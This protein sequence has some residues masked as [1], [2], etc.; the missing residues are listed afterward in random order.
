MMSQAGKQLQYTYCW[1]KRVKA[2]AKIKSNQTMK[3]GQL[4][5]S[6]VRNIF[7]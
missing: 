5:E 6:D 3:L 7:L 2:R 4:I 1:I